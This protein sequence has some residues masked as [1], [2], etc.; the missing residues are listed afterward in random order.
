MIV[1]NDTI[2]DL[3]HLLYRVP[4]EKVKGRE[5]RQVKAQDKEVKEEGKR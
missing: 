5:R 4:G 1:I 2:Y 3:P